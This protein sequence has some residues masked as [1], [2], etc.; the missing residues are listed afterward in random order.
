MQKENPSKIGDII[1]VDPKS[2]FTFF[3]KGGKRSN[4]P[5]TLEREKTG[6]VFEVKNVEDEES[7]EVPFEEIP[8]PKLK[9]PNDL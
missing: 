8:I 5:I 4:L 3:D 9:L 7:V 1:T 6:E 2:G